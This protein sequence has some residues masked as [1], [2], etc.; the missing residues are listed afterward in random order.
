M[1]NIFINII[2]VNLVIF[3]FGFV[4][5]QTFFNEKITKDNVYEIPLFGIIFLSFVVLVINF[6]FPINKIVGSFI[7]IFGIT[8]IIL[9]SYKNNHLF[10]KIFKNIIIAS[11]ISYLIIFFKCLDQMLACIICHL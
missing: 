11:F 4:C 7:L 5:S 2:I 1:I 8:N 3:S 6:F 10:K 9:I